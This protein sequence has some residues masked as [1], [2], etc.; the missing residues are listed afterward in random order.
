MLT[1]RNAAASFAILYLMSAVTPGLEMR[2]AFATEMPP[3]LSASRLLSPEILRSPDHQVSELVRNDGFMNHYEIN[4]RF[5][6]FKAGS[7]AELRKRSR[8]IGAITAMDKVKGT[9]E[10]GRAAKE[11]GKGIWDGAKGL[12]TQ[13][14]STVSNVV[15]G[16][17]KIFQRA[18]DSL[19]GDPASDAEDS[20][21]RDLIGFSKKKRENAAAYGVDPYSSNKVLQTYLDE[22]SWAGYA[23][24]LSVSLGVSAISGTVETAMQVAG[25]TDILADVMHT[26]PPV[27]LRRMNRERLAAMGV[28][29][30]LVDLFLGN[31]VFSPRNQTYLV[32]ALHEMKG[33]DNRSAFVKFSVRTEQRDEALYRQRQAQMYAGYHASVEAIDTFV[34]VGELVAART[35]S[36]KLVFNVP[37]DHLAWTK[38]LAQV[39]NYANRNAAAVRNTTDKE[40]WLAGT[41]SDITKTELRRLGWKIV[42]RTESKILATYW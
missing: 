8:E 29:A 20:R 33:V 4:S 15:S 39:A 2:Q 19:F 7:T 25:A 14:V 18:G 5:G 12:V 22:V 6:V 37:A 21:V 27:D 31:T 40:L 11:A 34:P 38:S 23:G 41:A 32:G 10:F 24:G 1:C 28:H 26:T 30:D 17:G 9:K 42:E 13:P 35:R 3:M 36:G 16:V